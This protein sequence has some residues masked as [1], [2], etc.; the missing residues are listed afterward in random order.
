MTTLSTFAM[1]TGLAGDRR[2]AA[3]AAS[4][5]PLAWIRRVMQTAAERRA[6]GELDAHRLRDIGLT[7]ED[8]RAEI[9]RSP[10][11]V[12]SRQG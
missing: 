3:L 12:P 9:N 2:G 7:E 10:F 11:D 4:K 8:V 1:L 6:L 5:A